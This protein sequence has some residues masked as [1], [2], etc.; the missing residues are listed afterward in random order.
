MKAL[1]DKLLNNPVFA[2]AVLQ[3]VALA[4]LPL[5]V[6]AAVVSV[7]EVVKRQLVTPN[8]KARRRA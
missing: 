5:E 3:A 6:S 1:G 8:R 2:V 7:L 4:A